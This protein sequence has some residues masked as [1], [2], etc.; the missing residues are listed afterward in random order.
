MPA[1]LGLA[2]MFGRLSTFYPGQGGPYGY[3]RAIFGQRTGQL[4]G[5]IHLLAML[6]SQAAVL[7]LLYET[8]IECVP[9][10]AVWVLIF[11]V[12]LCGLLQT[13]PYSLNLNI[14]LLLNV[15]KLTPF[16]CLIFVCLANTNLAGLP[17][18]VIDSINT[19]NLNPTDFK[20][21]LIMIMFAFGGMEFGTVMQTNCIREP[22]RVVPRAIYYGT[23]VSGAIFFSLQC[24]AGLLPIYPPNLP[25]FVVARAIL[26]WQAMSFGIMI[27]RDLIIE[28]RQNQDLFVPHGIV[29]P[30]FIATVIPL[31][32][33]LYGQTLTQDSFAMLVATCDLIFALIFL[34]CAIMY[35][36]K[37]R[38]DRISLLAILGSALFLWASCS[39]NSSFLA[40]C[41]IL[42]S[43]VYDTTSYDPA[44]HLGSQSHKLSDVLLGCDPCP[45]FVDLD[46]TL[47]CTDVPYDLYQSLSFWDR[48]HW[49]VRSVGRSSADAAAIG[50]QYV[51]KS[52]PRIKYRTELRSLL[53]LASRDRPIVLATG[54]PREI[55]DI[56]L[57]DCPFLQTALT[58]CIGTDKL[59]AIRSILDAQDADPTQGFTYIG[60]SEH[61]LP[62][63]AVARYPLVIVQNSNVHMIQQW[64]KI[65]PGL[66]AVL[67]D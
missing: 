20:D 18:L 10:Q 46:S 36:F 63:W 37:T 9:F 35:T 11:V 67:C 61:D 5:R 28:L 31:C 6:L 38:G 21:A 30:T 55:A 4:V 60:D 17:R 42:L 50:M 15:I 47:S 7:A 54:S 59:D 27:A 56:V 52:P 19:T 23:I 44:H 62:I 64:K 43:L 45:I 24:V 39:H 53:K 40:A 66:I 32:V 29:M 8:L 48:M 41:G 13:L 65:V 51:A 26:L 1:I 12:I 33:A 34:A 14:A 3:A 25:V 49:F 58:G 2:V 22:E 57:N 16:L